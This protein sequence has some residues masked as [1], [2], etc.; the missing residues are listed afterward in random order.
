MNVKTLLAAAALAFPAAMATAQ[1]DPAATPSTDQPADAPADA[2]AG[3]ATSADTPAAD[4]GAAANADVTAGATVL[5][6]NGGTVGTIESVE[7]DTAVLSTGSVRV[8]VPL[9]A[10]SKGDKGLTIAMSKAEVEAAAAANAAT[11]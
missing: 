3:A 1:A 5:D 7:G 6:P 8:G 10:I 4:A 2:T 11:N 9:S